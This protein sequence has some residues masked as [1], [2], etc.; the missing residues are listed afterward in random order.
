M[1]GDLAG[2]LRRLTP[3]RPYQDSLERDQLRMLC[4]YLRQNPELWPAFAQSLQSRS[5]LDSSQVRFLCFQ[6]THYVFCRSAHFRAHL[7]STYVLGFLNLFRQ[8]L[9]PP[10][11]FASRLRY[12]TPHVARH[13]SSRF[14]ALYP[15]LRILETEF[16]AT[17]SRAEALTDA[18]AESLD[19]LADMVVARHRNTLDEIRRLICLAPDGVSQ[20]ARGI[21]LEALRERR[22]GLREC[23]RDMDGLRMRAAMYPVPEELVAKIG[24][25]TEDVAALETGAIRIGLEDDEFVDVED[26]AQDA[27]EE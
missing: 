15:Q 5:A 4:H 7:C 19:Q 18:R 9:P 14:G 10:E 8:S 27:E 23:L 3:S 25:L 6:L 21:I 13:W 1:K 12:V 26:D 24:G 2:M 11:Q 16:A 17:R 22:E 20:E